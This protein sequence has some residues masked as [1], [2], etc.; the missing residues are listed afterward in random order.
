MHKNKGYKLI[1]K[2]IHNE[3]RKNIKANRTLKSKQFE[4][5][6]KYGEYLTMYNNNESFV[7]G[8]IKGLKKQYEERELLMRYPSKKYMDNDDSVVGEGLGEYTLEEIKNIFNGKKFD[9]KVIAASK[10]RIIF[11]VK[12]LEYVDTKGYMYKNH[13]DEEYYENETFLESLINVSKPKG[14][15]M[16]NSYYY[17]QIIENVGVSERYT[18]KGIK[19]S[20]ARFTK[21]EPAD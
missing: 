7:D 16:P 1:T 9:L 2:N 19:F 18:P 17:G 5:L 3:S 15:Y 8:L 11:E 6:L 20:L 14:K 21:Q 4:D 10:T 12:G 13:K